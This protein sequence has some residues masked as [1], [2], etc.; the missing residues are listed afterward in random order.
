MEFPSVTEMIL[1]IW[2]YSL[3][4]E[5]GVVAVFLSWFSVLGAGCAVWLTAKLML[6]VLFHYADTIYDHANRTR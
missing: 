5:Y 2:W 3:Q 1:Y 4:G 6:K